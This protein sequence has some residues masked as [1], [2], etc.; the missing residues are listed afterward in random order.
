[1]ALFY[2]SE[3][4]DSIKINQ[5]EKAAKKI[6]YTAETTFYDGENAK[7][8]IDVFFPEGV[9]NASVFQNEIYFEVSTQ[10]GLNKISYPSNVPLS[11]SFASTTSGVKV[12]TIE[13]NSDSV[14]IS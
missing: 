8:T 10:S 6:V 1:M 14:T 11:G 13:A 9:K 12:V 2:T 4:Q 3:I 7:A 5:L